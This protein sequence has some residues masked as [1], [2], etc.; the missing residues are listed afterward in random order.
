MDSESLRCIWRKGKESNPR[1]S[2]RDGIGI[3]TRRITALPPFR[4]LVAQAGIAPAP[5]GLQPDALL[6]ELPRVIWSRYEDLHPAHLVTKQVLCSM[7]YTGI[8]SAGR[9]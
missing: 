8:G 2:H 1:T 7:S 9:I 6:T 5:S 4:M 3:A